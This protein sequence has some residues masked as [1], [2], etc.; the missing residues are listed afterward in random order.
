MD[1]PEL[2]GQVGPSIARALE[3]A[4]QTQAGGARKAKMAKDALNRIIHGRRGDPRLSTLW[5]LADACD[6][7][8]DALVGRNAAS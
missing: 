4:G 5:K 8:L 2:L 7:S 3:R 6:T 1:E